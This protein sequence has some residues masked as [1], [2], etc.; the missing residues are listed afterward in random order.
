MFKVYDENDLCLSKDEYKFISSN[1]KLIADR[2]TKL[3]EMRTEVEDLLFKSLDLT[4]E[5]VLVR[6]QLLRQKHAALLNALGQLK[7]EDHDER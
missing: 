2:G 3:V 6:V 1:P 4:E 5:N 7:G